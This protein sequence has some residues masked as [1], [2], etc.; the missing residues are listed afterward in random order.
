[1]KLKI[2]ISLLFL[3]FTITAQQIE[4]FSIDSGGES[5]TSANTQLIYT[6][7]EVHIQE[8]NATNTKISEGFITPILFVSTANVNTNNIT[9]LSVFPNPISTFLKIKANEN[10]SKITIF[11]QLGQL[12]KILKINKTETTI[13]FSRISSGTYLLKI[14]VGTKT[15]TKQIIKK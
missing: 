11:N 5:F 15:I 10:L 1:M 14:E 3:S 13:N 12:V 9:N 4:K 7:G 8:L 6:I 2:F